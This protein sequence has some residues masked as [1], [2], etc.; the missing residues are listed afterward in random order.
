MKGTMFKVVLGQV[1]SVCSLALFALCI[2]LPSVYAY[3]LSI[4]DDL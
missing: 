3:C 4:A 1:S 2:V